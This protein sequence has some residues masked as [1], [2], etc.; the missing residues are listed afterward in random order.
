MAKNQVILYIKQIVPKES[1]SMTGCTKHE[2]YS[3]T[4]KYCVI[5]YVLEL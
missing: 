5:K 3:N 4:E 1:N 2:I